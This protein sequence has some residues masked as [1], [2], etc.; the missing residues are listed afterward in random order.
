MAVPSI[1]RLRS[2]PPT[3]LLLVLSAAIGSCAI[4]FYCLLIGITIVVS[5]LLYIP[6]IL[7]AFYYPR[8]G[9]PFAIGIAAL[10]FTMVVMTRSAYA[11]DLI[12]AAARCVVFVL[13]ASVV[14][15][16]SLR[17]NEE[18]ER[19]IMAR[20]EWERTFD[21]VPDLIAL[22]DFNYRILRINRSMAEKLGVS[23]EQ[24]IGLLCYEVVHCTHEP[25]N[26]CPHT[27]LMLDG[28]EHTSEVS[29]GCF[30]GDYLV[31]VSPLRDDHGNLIGSVHIARDITESR[32]M[33]K[34]AEFHTKELERYNEAL[35]QA[36]RKLN[37]LS[38]ITRH[39]ILNKITAVLA[40]LELSQ[41]LTKDPSLLDYIQREIETVRAIE[42]QIDF[43]HYYQ[44]IGVRAPEWQDVASTVRRAAAQL[45]LSDIP[46]K[47]QFDGISIY[48][49]PLIE[50][51]FYNLLENTV[52]HGEHVTEI[53]FS[54]E[55]TDDVL[56]I[57]YED[58]GVGIAPEIKE[59]IFIRGFGKHTG[60]GLFL[61]REIL[62]ITGITIAE[63]GEY[64]KG[65]RFEI[66]VPIDRYRRS[67]SSTDVQ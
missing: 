45:P 63:T 23:A 8:R 32:A 41:E 39:D 37:I 65:V 5:H 44:D 2:H 61:I 59:K 4:N 27:R 12:S 24:A 42:R 57:L 34:K 64:G 28:K 25:P 31:T 56:T 33:K 16:L 38:Q 21:A 14:S 36:N 62:S 26:F 58:N 49:D 35:E 50:K 19:H 9:V 1:D 55:K 43:T 17:L 48:A 11:T 52:R 46:L 29:D 30:G 40:Y 18:Q 7:A 53:L 6:I 10:Y 15:Y 22:I 54:L 66:R 20:E 60:L 67:V 47:V 51:V 13:I 3:P